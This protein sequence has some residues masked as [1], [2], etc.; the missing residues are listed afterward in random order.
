[1]LVPLGGG[2]KRKCRDR[3]GEPG[4]FFLCC[5]DFC[6]GQLVDDPVD[7]VEVDDGRFA[8]LAEKAGIFSSPFIQGG[9]GSAAVVNR[10][11]NS[12]GAGPKACGRYG[13]LHLVV[14]ESRT[15]ANV[16][17]LVLSTR[18]SKCTYLPKNLTF[19]L[20]DPNCAQGKS[21]FFQ[22]FGN[23]RTTNFL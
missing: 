18:S 21:K 22:H 8:I 17:G 3:F 16:E 11:W 12:S 9:A 13:H 5:L 10:C 1:C 7:H 15:G 19:K 2:R 14:D 20:F 23:D 4:L 6:G